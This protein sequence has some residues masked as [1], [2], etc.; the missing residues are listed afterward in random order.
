MTTMPKRLFII[1]LAVF[2]FVFTGCHHEAEP[3][4][5]PE[6]PSLHVTMTPLQLES[7]LANRD[8]KVPANALLIDAQGDTLFEGELSYIKTRGNTSFKENKKPFAVKFLKKQSFLGLERAK[9]FVLLANA[10]DESHIRNAIAFDL[11]RA[12]GIPAPRYAFLTLY[13]NGSYRGLYQI[14]NKVDVGMDALNITNLDKQNEMV[15]P[16]P[17]EEYEWYGLGRRQQ[18]VLRKGVLLDHDP[19]DI[20]GGYLLDISGPRPPYQRSYSGF[21]S[22]ANDNIRLL[23]PK[24][25]SP[26]EMDYIAGRYNEMESA[27]HAPDGICP[28]T[29]RHYSEYLDIESF[30]R[31]YLLNELLVNLDGGWSSFYIYKDADNIDPKFHAGPAWDYDR[32]LDNSHFQNTLIVFPNMLFVCEKN[33]KRGFVSSGGLLYYL[34]QHEDFQQT[35]RD[36]YLNGI[37]EACHNYL[38]QSS[39]DSLAVLLSHEADLD[40]AKYETRI[41]AD[42]ASATKRVADFLRE[43]IAFFDWWYGSSMEEGAV[44]VRYTMRIGRDVMFGYRLGEAVNAPQVTKAVYNHDPIYT[45]YYPGTDSV[46]SDGTVFQTP[47]KLDLRKREPTKKEVQMRRIKKK[48]RKIGVDL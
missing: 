40:N 1:V 27:V 36:C 24:Y 35:V 4:E 16:K 6:L 21:V 19:D 8:N 42:Y 39:F 46:V 28:E 43:R 44:T 9:S 33:G 20:T 34:C 25:A 31:Y 30:A 3:Q 11:A 15:N 14:T 5:S 13:I 29:G 32:S 10:C 23:S 12:M 47:Q 45:L 37:G 38:E 22:N 26:R 2:A 48:L 41:S 17:L 18:M 7:V